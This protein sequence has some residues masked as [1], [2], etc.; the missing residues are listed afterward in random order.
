MGSG[1]ETGKSGRKERKPTHGRSHEQEKAG[2]IATTPLSFRIYTR[3]VGREG[4]AR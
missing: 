2:K 3:L 1:G 4:V